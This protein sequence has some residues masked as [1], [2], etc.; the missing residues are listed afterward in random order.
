MNLR[1]FLRMMIPVC[2]LAAVSCTNEELILDA[3]QTQR[4]REFAQAFKARFGEIDPN[5]TWVDGSV[6]KVTVTTDQPANIVIYGLGR[7]DGTL[8]RLKRCVV[9]GTQEVK[10]DIPAGCQKVVLRAYN[11]GNNFN[12]YKTLDP[13]NENDVADMT[14]A[15]TRAS[16]ATTMEEYMQQNNPRARQLIPNVWNAYTSHGYPAPWQTTI[17]ETSSL[18]L[19]YVDYSGIDDNASG[20]NFFFRGT[21]GYLYNIHTWDQLNDYMPVSLFTSID[22]FHEK[23]GFTAADNVANGGNGYRIVTFAEG[24]KWTSHPS[25]AP[26]GGFESGRKYP[27]GTY[28]NFAAYGKRGSWWK[29]DTD[30]Y[31]KFYVTN[32]DITD[33][34]TGTLSGVQDYFKKTLNAEVISEIEKIVVPDNQY[35][36]LR[37]YVTDAGFTTL[38]PGP[39]TV[40]WF[41][42]VT[43]T[44]DY[45][46]YYYT[47]GEDT[48]A[49]EAAAD[50]YL[51]LDAHSSSRQ[52]GD[53][54]PLTYYDANGDASYIFPKDV[55]I[56]FFVVHGRGSSTN[57]PHPHSGYTSWSSGNMNNW[58]F[59]DTTKSDGT[60]E[61]GWTLDAWYAAYSQGGAIN[62]PAYNRLYDEDSKPDSRITSDFGGNYIPSMSFNYAGYNVIGFEDTPTGVDL[63]WN[64]C[65]FIVNGNFE[66]KKWHQQDLA[67]SMCME[68]LGGTDDLDYND[69]F[70]VVT[71]GYEEITTTGDVTETYYSA[72]KVMIPM[73]GGTLPLRI[74]FAP[75]DATYEHL[76]QTLFSDVHAAFGSGLTDVAINTCLPNEYSTN[77][78]NITGTP[79]YNGTPFTVDFADGATVKCANFKA[80]NDTEAEDV[81]TIF[82]GTLFTSTDIANFSILDHIPDFKIYVT[83]EDGEEMCISGPKNLQVGQDTSDEQKIPFAFWFPSTAESEQASADNPETRVLPGYERQFINTA[84]P[85]FA[86]WVANQN[87]TGTRWYDWAWGYDT[88]WP[89][90]NPGGGSQGG[91]G[92]GEGGQTETSKT[93][94]F[95]GSNVVS[96]PF[97]WDGNSYGIRISQSNLVS[98]PT[99]IQVV[100]TFTDSQYQDVEFADLN[101]T[102]GTWSH[103]I[104][105]TT[106]S[107]SVDLNDYASSYANGFIIYAHSANFV[108]YLESVTIT[109]SNE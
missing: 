106:N 19:Q 8:L 15:G 87:H 91:G 93:V 92:S 21:D 83:Y 75:E 88:N 59:Y 2:A 100:M 37:P 71:Q 107:I 46:G 33:S 52:K 97:G 13:G 94:S 6:G 98:N 5:H 27:A 22:E 28:Y 78:R 24:E 77:I 76:T 40:T 44:R 86:Q 38:A 42:G 109:S 26:G 69:L 43:S 79:D 50:K 55:N 60:N 61:N 36:L 62:D 12:E 34:H 49:K 16:N 66:V 95:T 84:I 56:H 4:G 48:E 54:F 35:D 103:R 14:A 102:N 63:D 73:A 53:T 57:K 20:W 3:S 47:T 17:P 82:P 108:N 105:Q 85:G 9:N 29:H 25:I 67:F 72:P 68:D 7:T 99:S 58:L 1:K 64:D 74:E 30:D 32:M 96:N 11:N 80:R 18:T 23:S 104:Q 70:M 45:V 65:T 90:N 101:G 10:Y 31:G 41:T 81:T 51:L 39:V 89:E